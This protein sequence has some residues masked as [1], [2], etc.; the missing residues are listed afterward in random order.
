[1]KKLALSFLFFACS[2]PAWAARPF[3][4]DDARLTTEGSCQLESWTRAYPDSQELWALP[5]CNP[6]GNFEMT[7]GMGVAQADSGTVTHDYVLQAKTLFKPLETNRWGIGLGMGKVFHPE[8]TPGP[9]QTGNTYAYVP[10]SV[11][12]DNDKV[13]MHVN[14]GWLRD[15]ASKQDNMTWGVGGEFK[16]T[17]RLTAILETYGD[18]RTTPYGQAGLRFA[19]VPNLFQIDATAGRQFNGVD[20][21]QWLSFG[22]RLTPEH[23]F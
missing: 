7:L 12:F 13:V 23:L 5:A 4:T 14:V 15:K 2:Y 11:S 16:M 19:V 8:V 17:P 22:I 21:N 6:T 10:L 1:M 18:H 9:N 3:V 20:D